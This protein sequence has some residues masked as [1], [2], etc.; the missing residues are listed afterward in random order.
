MSVEVTL[1][2]SQDRLCDITFDP[3]TPSIV[4]D[5]HFY[6]MFYAT[7]GRIELGEQLIRRDSNQTAAE[8]QWQMASEVL[9]KIGMPSN[10]TKELVGRLTKGEKRIVVKCET[11]TYL[12]EELPLG[13]KDNEHIGY[14]YKLSPPKK[15]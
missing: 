15:E 5:G 6:Q 12:P 2:P 10:M 3:G 11:R 9:S 7:M 8:E 14:N 13:I 4:H 1:R